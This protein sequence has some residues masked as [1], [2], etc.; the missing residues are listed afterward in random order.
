M[1]HNTFYTHSGAKVIYFSSIYKFLG[2][3]F[4]NNH[5]C[6]R[7]GNKTY[8]IDRGYI[9]VDFNNTIFTTFPL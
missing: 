6:G 3:Y 4:Q 2:E 5:I 7:G 1:P 8:Y 9:D